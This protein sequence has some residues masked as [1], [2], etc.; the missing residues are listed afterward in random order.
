VGEYLSSTEFQSSA[1]KAFEAGH[2][3]GELGLT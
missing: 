3:K 1:M 2:A